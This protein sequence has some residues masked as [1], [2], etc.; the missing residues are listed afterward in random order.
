MP[1]NL[2]DKLRGY[3]KKVTADLGRAREQLQERE[4]AAT[5]AIAIIGMSCRL[6]G[7][8]TGPAELWQ[9]VTD[10]VDAIAPA[11]ADRAWAS[12]ELTGTA[13]LGGFLDDAG[14][15]DAAFF[16]MSPREALA[17][18]PQQ[19]LLLE[20]AWEAL[21]S[22]HIDP[23]SLRASTT[24]VFAGTNGQDHGA[25]LPSSA[26]AGFGSTATSASVLSGRVSYTFGFQGPAVT[27]DTAC[28]SSLVAL[29]LAVQSLRQG[30]SALALAGG[31]TVMTTP[32]LFVE[33]TRQG[34]L[35]HD[36]RCRS[37]AAEADG[38]GW[39]EGVGWLLLERLS[40]AR[41]HG[42]RILAVVRG[43]AVNQDGASNGLTA[44]NGR[45]QQHV[46]RQALHNAR[47]TPRDVDAVE[48][49]GTGTRLGDPIEAEALL[50]TY[51]QNREHPLLL[52]SVKSN[53]GHAQA[54]AGV[55]GVIKMVQAIRRGWLPRTLHAEQPAPGVR[56]GSGRVSLLTD[57]VEWPVTGAPRR[58]AVSSFGISG[59]NA[60]VI[61]EQAP[62][63]EPIADAPAP[64]TVAWPLSARSEAALRTQANRLAMHPG[65]ATGIGRAL[66]ARSALDHRAVVLGA[67]LGELQDELS[68]LAAGEGTVGKPVSGS[69]A[70][71][72][73]GQG[74]QRVGMG[75]ELYGRYP[76]FAAAFDEVAALLPVDL[77]GDMGLTG[78]AQPA[79]FAFEVALFRLV[80]SWGVC[81]AFVGGHSVGEIAAA[82]VA[83][84]LSLSDAC[85][86][87]EARA[88][89]MQALP[90]GGV[91][92]AVAASEDVV[93]PLLSGVVDIAAVNGSEA[94][95]L[96]GVEGAVEG[97]VAALGGVRSRRLGV[98]HAFH[99]ALMDPMLDDF[100]AVVEGL[101]FG[102]ARIPLVRDVSSPGY[103][104]R[105]VRECV[106]FA[107]DVAAL[108]AAGVSTFL[109]LG[110]D[111]VLSG[112]GEGEWVPAQRRDHGEVSTL[113]AALGRI[114]VRG[115]DIDWAVLLPGAM[116]EDV[117]TY[118]FQHERY[119][120]T[121]TAADA[122]TIGLLTSE[123]PLLLGESS[124][125]DTG[126]AVFTGTVSLRTHPWLA[127][128]VIG[129]RPI[130]PGTAL[131]D[132]ALHAGHRVDLPDVE[133]LTLHAPLPLGDRLVALQVTV[134][135]A[136][137]DRRRPIA[138]HSRP[139]GPDANLTTLDW[140]CH[141]TGVLTRSAAAP[142]AMDL[143]DWPPRDAIAVTVDY[144]RLISHGY[145]YGPAFRGLRQVWRRD[146]E[147]FAEVALPVDAGTFGLHPAL[148]DAALHAA[149]VS[150]AVED[151]P[152]VTRLPFSWNGVHLAAVGAGAL[153]VRLSL[154]SEDAMAIVVADDTG[155]PV[156]TARSLVSRTVAIASSEPD[157]SDALFHT[158]WQ[159]LPFGTPEGILW[160]QLSEVEGDAPA[161]IRLDVPRPE[162]AVSEAVRM[163]TG[164]ILT[165]VQAFLADDRFETS[166]LVVVTRNAHAP[167]TAADVVSAAVWGLLRSA[168]TENPGRLL[169]VDLD[170]DPRSAAVLTAAVRAA[171][172]AGEDQLIL[173]AGEASVPRLQRVDRSG[174]L[175]VPGG[176]WR[177]G[178]GE[179]GV[180]EGLVLEGVEVVALG[181]GEVRVA[182]RAGGVNFRDVLMAL[183]VYPGEPSLGA[184]GAGVVVEVGP[185]V[186][187]LGV[188]DRVF[189]VFGGAFGS[190]VVADRRGLVRIPCGWSFEQAAAVP[191]AFLTA[192]YGLVD[193]AGLRRGQSVLIHAAAGGVGMAA[194]Q[195]ARFLG[196]EVYATAS[197]WKWGEVEA[198]GVAGDRLA[199]SRTLE[200]ADRFPKVDVVLNSLTG[201]FVDASLGLLVS[202]GCFLEMGV[203]DVREGVGVGY[204]P[205]QLLEAGYDRLGE[206]LVELVGL[207]SV[208]ELVLPPVRVW[209]V[210]RAVEAFRFVSQ[211][212]HVGKVVLRMPRVVDPDGTVLITGASGMLGGVAAR[213]V[214]G[215]GVRR[216]LLVS[217]GGVSGEL[218]AELRGAGAVVT[219]VECDVADRGVLAGVLAGVPV[220]HP[221]T[222]VVHTAGTLDDAPFTALTP[223]RV[224]DVLSAKADGAW[225]LH[226]LTADADLAV[227][228]MYSSA[229]GVLG[230]AGQ[231]AYN[232]ANTFTDALA[233]LRHHQGL[234]G[235]A[236]AWGPWAATGGMT[237]RLGG[238]DRARQAR[239]GARPIAEADGCALLTA[240]LDR[241]EPV[242]VPIRL[243]TAG[244][245]AASDIPPLLRGLVRQ[246]RP[247]VATPAT[248]DRQS[249]TRRLRDLPAGEAAHAA[250]ELVRD[251]AALVLGHASGA[252][253]SPA[254]AFRDLGFDSLTAVELRNRLTA[255]TGLSLPA[256]VVF[257]HPTAQA[258][259]QLV[260][261][262]LGPVGPDP[263][264]DVLAELDRLES[265][266]A[267]APHDSDVDRQLVRRLR[268]ILDE[269]TRTFH[270][271]GGSAEPQHFADALEAAGA[272]DV[273]KLIDARLGR[274]TRP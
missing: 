30:E 6:P 179:V 89:L 91:M 8:V 114:W 97:V 58:A 136:H 96:S 222:A 105:Q 106:R 253:I 205:F 263:G 122:T 84:V 260:L 38:T 159:P 225:H 265:V 42:R 186:S 238:A 154:D 9:L 239:T 215:R 85:C 138:V 144:E 26:F 108:A 241:D 182:V 248:P 185:G 149:I 194:V 217:R 178:V 135:P 86:L 254:D 172:V 95:V 189:G 120:L 131:L 51:G 61:L 12:A 59:T 214:V 126:A 251:Q 116:P 151:S 33:F 266:L 166:R 37:F 243:D 98:S 140:T 94:V 46:I 55:A 71:M 164:E 176:V 252:S 67:E 173:R 87:V 50:A 261:D 171:V 221:L 203:A 109:E 234:P 228:A 231:A 158:N 167:G 43:S 204:R 62:D 121:A 193:L 152:A 262:R 187:G 29:H 27:V 169:L 236:L 200:F 139:A 247:S 25:G 40:D 79:L 146:K 213:Y 32:E 35:S 74:A 123:H 110:P 183:G 45:A 175:D 81:P 168:Q 118:A 15:F 245:A 119:W 39:G 206:M 197:P 210:R 80:E 125:A 23:E 273:L 41:R 156:L 47:L 76:V 113:L 268:K 227:F 218:V 93:R 11:P 107:D 78:V 103:W 269:R 21:E 102:V 212:R 274:R 148:L 163:V 211:A 5:E 188:G 229:A 208:G 256:T 18:D 24:A 224:H 257:D 180:L 177:L 233:G 226:E 270:P 1:E 199:S 70:V 75:A 56:W 104:V 207:F 2:E 44:P 235:T 202:G 195:V 83:G 130:L 3:L 128:H 99:S 73:T 127:D 230:S 190:V 165:A 240:A 181:V 143:T 246:R 88:R 66:A 162:L 101:S 255:A 31:V 242:L 82:H 134:G 115:A 14:G 219:V 57:A 64:A 10:G 63:T 223:S 77:D 271:A 249:L 259:S 68:R 250:L 201:E 112:M 216:V 7:G 124:I 161:V 137:D 145:G 16:G 272:E 191:V 132:L 49:H 232:A 150:A 100:A 60:H 142:A 28:S 258:L 198:L 129:G 117:P 267:A 111:G 220:E 36:G 170:E 13:P 54:A 133:E 69:L 237:E 184:E 209:D 141:A 72:F 157:T 20:T 22:A 153:R 155:G 34:G 53:I 264:T 19:R 92:V 244:L 65:T 160:P 4:D 52:G 90:A 196:A 17:T 48:A 147:I 174:L 192:W